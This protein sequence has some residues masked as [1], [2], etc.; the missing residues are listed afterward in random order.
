MTQTNPV[1]LSN[2]QTTVYQSGSSQPSLWERT[3]WNWKWKWQ[4]NKYGHLNLDCYN[5]MIKL[6]RNFV[7]ASAFVSM[8]CYEVW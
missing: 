7:L 6:W 2:W 1:P 8:A 3:L 4:K 5:E